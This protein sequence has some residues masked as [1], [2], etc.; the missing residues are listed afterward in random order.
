M[1]LSSSG[2]LSLALISWQIPDAFYLQIFV[3][4]GIIPFAPFLLLMT[5]S[6]KWLLATSRRAECRESLKQIMKINSLKRDINLPEIE[7]GMC[8]ESKLPGLVPDSNDQEKCDR[9]ELLLV[10][11]RHS[12]LRPFPQHARVQ[13]R[14]E[15]QHF[16]QEPQKPGKHTGV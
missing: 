10:R 8:S 5:E 3:A 6:P 13:G 14:P 4:V 15:E 1:S 16:S 12:L 7:A 2:Y 11:S 9:D